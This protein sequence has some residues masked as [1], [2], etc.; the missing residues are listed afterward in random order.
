V[1]N[2]LQSDVRW[3][4]PKCTCKCGAANGVLNPP[5]A[6]TNVPLS[7]LPDGDVHGT[8]QTPRDS[9]GG[10]RLPSFPIRGGLDDGSTAPRGAYAEMDILST[11]GLSRVPPSILPYSSLHNSAARLGNDVLALQYNLQTATSGYNLE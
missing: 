10:M 11:G 5:A 9:T 1:P 8:G 4:L 6:A 3:T 2:N 7:A